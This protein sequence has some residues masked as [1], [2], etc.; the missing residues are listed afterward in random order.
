ME[1]EIKRPSLLTSKDYGQKGFTLIELIMVIVILGILVAVAVPK[2]QSLKGD[3]STAAAN[4]M[5]A[6]A[7]AACAINFANNMLHP[8]G[9]LITNGATLLGAMDNPPSDWAVPAGGETSPPTIVATISGTPY[10]ITIT[11]V[12]TAT[13]KAALSKSW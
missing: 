7:Q 1:K 11:S 13:S 5:Y 12:E 8:G 4:G 6:G 3:A 10:T 9:T 2:Y